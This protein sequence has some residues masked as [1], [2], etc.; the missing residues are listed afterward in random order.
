VR[1]V[2]STSPTGNNGLLQ[3]VSTLSECVRSSEI[4]PFQVTF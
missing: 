4:L 2:S 1:I 3:S